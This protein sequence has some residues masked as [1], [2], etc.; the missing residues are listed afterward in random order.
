MRSVAPYPHFRPTGKP[1]YVN[2]S[3]ATKHRVKA[4]NRYNFRVYGYRK[5]I[6]ESYSV[7]KVIVHSGV[8]TENGD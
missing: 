3:T 5:S 1:K 8:G 6:T 2:P 4:I 7:R